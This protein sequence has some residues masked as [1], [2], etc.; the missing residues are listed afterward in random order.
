MPE[1]V[2]AGASGGLCLQLDG[3]H[4]KPETRQTEAD[5]PGDGLKRQPVLGMAMELR[6]DKLSQGR[7]GS[8]SKAVESRS[9]STKELVALGFA[10]KPIWAVV[11]AGWVELWSRKSFGGDL[12]WRRK[13]G[14]P[15]SG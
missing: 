14:T 5:S 10:Y 11:R 6:E 4:Q 8:L 15:D 2:H 7:V 9:P 12:K 13:A 1:S 3:T